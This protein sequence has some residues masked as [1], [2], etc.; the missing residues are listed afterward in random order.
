LI[1]LAARLKAGGLRF[2]PGRA[3]QYFLRLVANS[4]KSLPSPGEIQGILLHHPPPI[5]LLAVKL[6]DEQVVAR[7]VSDPR[8]PM[9][10]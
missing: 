5:P 2:K 7:P 9:R 1:K 6:F 4:K 8:C 3:G 10:C